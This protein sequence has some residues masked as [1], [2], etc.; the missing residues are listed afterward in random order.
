MEIVIKMERIG[1]SQDQ[2]YSITFLGTGEVFF[3]SNGEANAQ[4][5]QLS[6]H[7]FK[8]IMREFE[9]MYFFDLKDEYGMNTGSGVVT[10]IS[11]AVDS[12][13]KSVKFSQS[14]KVP[15]PLLRLSAHLD[16]FIG[17]KG[18]EAR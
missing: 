9:N 4:V 6:Q 7:A 17:L 18:Y 3:E 12:K 13:T 2:Y 14:F 8:H 10:T 5:L 15:R 16:S 11:I 1:P